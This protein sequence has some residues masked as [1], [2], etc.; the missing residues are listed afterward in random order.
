MCKKLTVS[1]ASAIAD[2]LSPVN[3]R[4]VRVGRIAQELTFLVVAQNYIDKL[5]ATVHD[6]EVGDVRAGPDEGGLQ[7]R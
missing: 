4:T 5:A 1:A 2:Q 7:A 3:E 6:P